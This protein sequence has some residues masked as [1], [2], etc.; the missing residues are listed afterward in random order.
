MDED[1]GSMQEQSRQ[2]DVL[3]MCV[4]V[5]ANIVGILCIWPVIHAA[6]MDG[7]A[8]VQLVYVMQAWVTIM[9]CNFYWCTPNM[10]LFLVYF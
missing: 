2:N 10:H 7:A 8:W 9:I 3:G 5:W 6:G 4:L 1:D